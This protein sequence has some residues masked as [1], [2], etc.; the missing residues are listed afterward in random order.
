M[1]HTRYC[2]NPN[3]SQ[4]G[5]SSSRR[6]LWFYLI[7]ALSIG[8]VASVM[9]SYAST[10][11]TSIFSVVLVLGAIAACFYNYGVEIVKAPVRWL[12][13]AFVREDAMIFLELTFESLDEKT[14]SCPD[15]S[16]QQIETREGLLR[17]MEERS[18]RVVITYA[19][20]DTFGTMILVLLNVCILLYLMLLHDRHRHGHRPWSVGVMLLGEVVLLV[21]SPL[22]ARRLTRSI[23]FLKRLVDRWSSHPL[24]GTS[25]FLRGFIKRGP[26]SGEPS[27]R[28]QNAADWVSEH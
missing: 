8:T 24:P 13:K 17:Q 1:I 14:S 6:L 28:P 11:T 16:N 18:R 20:L 7:A 5:I 27:V 15:E 9:Q 10:S 2:I 22:L 4:R 21:S 23:P 25:D 3:T 19:V 12:L 26:P